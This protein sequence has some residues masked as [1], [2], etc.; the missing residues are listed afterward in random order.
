MATEVCAILL[1]RSHMRQ[2][3]RTSG[4][5]RDSKIR[6]KT[7]MRLSAP[8]IRSAWRTSSFRPDRMRHRTTLDTSLKVEEQLPCLLVR[9]EVGELRWPWRRVSSDTE[10]RGHPEQSVLTVQQRHLLVRALD[11][12]DLCGKVL[13]RMVHDAI[14]NGN[15]DRESRT[16]VCR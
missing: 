11:E 12:S 13:I 8:R 4:L 14:Q 10:T 3:I 1:S 7:F 16:T 9:V 6:W 15:R 5:W 2:A